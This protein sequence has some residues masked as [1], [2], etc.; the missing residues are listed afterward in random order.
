VNRRTKQMG[1]ILALIAM[2]VFTLPL[3]S[4]MYFQSSNAALVRRTKALV[5]RNP[6][7]Q[8]AWDQ[9]LQDKVLTSS[10]AKS[11]ADSAG[12]KSGP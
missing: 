9:A 4:W 11:I 2:V 10:E 3:F 12:A 5:E 6:Q 1:A 7:L 8:A